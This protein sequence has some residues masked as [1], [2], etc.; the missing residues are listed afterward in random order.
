MGAQLK[1]AVHRHVALSGGAC[2]QEAKGKADHLIRH[3]GSQ[4]YALILGGGDE[5]RER[6]DLQVFHAPGLALDL[7]ALPDFL[8]CG[9]WPDEHVRCHMRVLVV[10]FASPNY[11]MSTPSR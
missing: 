8:N 6:H 3:K 11:N 4:Q 1:T 5:H 7:L 9:E 2:A 10:V